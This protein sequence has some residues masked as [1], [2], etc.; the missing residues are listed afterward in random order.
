MNCEFVNKHI[1][2]YLEGRL[3]A[4]DRNEFIRHVDE[5]PSCE[6]EVVAYR[7]MFS[8]LRELERF[9]A[10]PGLQGVVVSRLKEQG[11][12][13]PRRVPV[14][15]KVLERFMAMPGAA[16]YPLAA[17]VVVACLYFPLA[18]LIGLA[19]GFAVSFT[20]FVTNLYTVASNAVGGIVLFERVLDSFGRYGKAIGALFRALGTAAGENAWLLGIGAATL[21]TIILIV[22][23]V[24]R[25]KR[26]TH[27]SYLF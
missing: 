5:C 24:T 27:A 3:V 23:M 25:R 2:D 1:Q 12:I 15:I 17:A 9:H 14:V 20:D 8:G 7:E 13:Y 4:L 10:P 19:R 11:V 16:R 21:L 18:A 26:S 6:E 22:S